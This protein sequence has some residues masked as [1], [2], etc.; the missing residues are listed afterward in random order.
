MRT[1]PGPGREADSVWKTPS[2]IA[3]STE[4]PGMTAHQFGYQVTP[5][6]K[7][8]SWTKLLLDRNSRATEYDDP[9]LKGTE[10]DG[11]LRL[12]PGKTA[13]E[14]VT[15]YLHEIYNWIFNMISNRI[16]VEVLA[17]T[18]M[19]FWFTVPAIWSDRAKS[20]TIMAAKNAGFAGRDA[21]SI[22]LIPEPE[23]AGVA[24]L[25]GL[26]EGSSA[27]KI[28][29]G[30]G[31]LIC[32]CGGG[33]VDIT[34]YRVIQ[35]RPKLEFEELV[36]GV[37]GKCGSTYIDRAFHRWM[38]ATFGRK[39]DDLSFEKIG[40]GSRFMKEF[41]SFKRDFGYSSSRGPDYSIDLETFYEIN[42]V[43]PRAKDSTHYDS[44][45]SVVKLQG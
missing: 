25:K 7:S 27:T 3:Y 29:N 42:L 43:I 45:E 21:D 4:N 41:E 19:E 1:W 33:T 8:Y 10:G 39:F 31:I 15:D 12:P 20:A 34:S 13:E 5:K 44:D 28:N 22:R 38:S 35:V 36:E 32:D 30:D 6:M 2:R 17:M 40:P 23:A 18:P 11:M 16:S 9:S 24:T 37:G 26:A 14:V